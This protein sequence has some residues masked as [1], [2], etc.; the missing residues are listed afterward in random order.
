[1]DF[2]WSITSVHTKTDQMFGDVVVE[3]YWK[4]LGS[5]SNGINGYFDGSTPLKIADITQDTFINF[6]Q[7]TE[8]KVIEWVKLSMTDAHYSSITTL[9]QKQ[10]DTQLNPVIEKPLPWLNQAGV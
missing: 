9:I 4:V 3:V 8:E 6:D 5:D 2:K 1:M 10:V 7:L